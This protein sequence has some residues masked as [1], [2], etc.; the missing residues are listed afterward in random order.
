MGAAIPYFEY[1]LSAAVIVRLFDDDLVVVLRRAVL[2]LPVWRRASMSYRIIFLVFV[3]LG[4][5]VSAKN[6]L[7]LGDLMIM[8][9]AVPKSSGC[10]CSPEASSGTSTNTGG[11]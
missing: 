8:G 1:V 4:S 5:V 3:F 7:E 6:V 2:G 10:S 9:M 11:G